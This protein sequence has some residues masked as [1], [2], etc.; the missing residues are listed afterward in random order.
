MFKYLQF[1]VYQVGLRLFVSD[2]V[3]DR[4]DSVSDFF[5]G[6]AVIVGS[7]E[8]NNHLKGGRVSQ[9]NWEGGFDVQSGWGRGEHTRL[10]FT[11]LII[12]LRLF[13]RVGN[14]ASRIEP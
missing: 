14:K 3:D 5:G 11:F 6:I 8:K 9:I 10:F 2:V 12:L 1:F 7:H 4:L 13:R